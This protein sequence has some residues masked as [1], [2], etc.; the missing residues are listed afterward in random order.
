MSSRRPP[1]HRCSGSRAM[2]SYEGTSRSSR[3]RRSVV[4]PTRCV[5]VWRDVSLQALDSLCVFNP[6][7]RLPRRTGWNVVVQLA[8]DQLGLF[9][10]SQN[11][12]SFGVDEAGL[13]SRIET[14]PRP[15]AAS[16]GNL[17]R[18]VVFRDRDD[19]VPGGDHGVHRRIDQSS[20]PSSLKMPITADSLKEKM[21]VS[22]GL[23]D[24]RR[25]LGEVDLRAVEVE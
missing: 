8:D 15:G 6:S 24:Q 14:G 17:Q 7:R 2:W 9:V 16:P 18:V 10:P 13:L 4:L 3:T 20:F 21:A 12:R 22:V 1:A 5:I 25:L 23:A 11:E 19:L